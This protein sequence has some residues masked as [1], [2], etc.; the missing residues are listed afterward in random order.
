MILAGSLVIGSFNDGL[1]LVLSSAVL[2]IFV[3]LALNVFTKPSLS[4]ITRW[5]TPLVILAGLLVAGYLA[6]VETTLTE[7]TC[8]AVGNCNTVQQS[9]YAQIA[10]IPIGVI[11]IIAYVA[12]LLV[13]AFAQYRKHATATWLLFGLALAGVV[14]SIYLTFLEPFVIGASCVWCLTSAVVM[15]ILLWLS[16]PSQQ[17]H[18]T[19][20]ER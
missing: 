5:A 3:A 18:V 20:R 2:V 6:Y 10:G 19:I 11:G 7:A 4:Q 1:T 9:S 12:M 13:W 14:F 16:L 15:T 17:L 8:G